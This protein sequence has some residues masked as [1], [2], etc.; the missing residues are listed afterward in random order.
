[1]LHYYLSCNDNGDDVRDGVHVRVHV[2]QYGSYHYDVLNCL[3]CSCDDVDD[4]CDGDD[5]AR[6]HMN[7]DLYDCD[8]NDE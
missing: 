6:D 4:A 8:G 1:V 2:V 5:D 3:N 7:Y